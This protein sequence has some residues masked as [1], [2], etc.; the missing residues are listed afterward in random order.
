MRILF[1]TDGS[2]NALE[3]ARLLASLPLGAGASIAVVTVAPE[4]RAAKGEAALEAAREALSGA[5]AAVETGVRHGHPAEE[6][7]R[8][9]EARPT[10]L[11][12]MGA[13]GMSGLARFFLGSVAERVARHAPCPVLVVRPGHLPLESVVL[14]VDGSEC[15]VRAA[16]WL[17]DFP[18]PEGC[19]VRIYT[20]LPVYEIGT[21]SASTEPPYPAATL[22]TLH[23]QERE[24][25]LERLRELEASFAAAGKRA[26]S[27]IRE[28]DPAVGI[29]QVIEDRDADLV[30][31]GSEGL[32]AFER[33]L[34]G[35]VSE[36]ILRHAHCSV[37]VVKQR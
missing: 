29:L 33:F 2:S 9:A 13:S 15:S 26:S 20:S 34:L 21:W 16:E 3:A 19:E 4:D 18:L 14:A 12:V 35:S 37:L 28:A 11:I 22:K 30:V 31:V 10:G 27:E 36:K 24:A 5:G 6:I 32:G 17:R 7:L 25:A 23:E 1:A 8:E